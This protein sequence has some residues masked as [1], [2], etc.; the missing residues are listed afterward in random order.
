MTNKAFLDEPVA[1]ILIEGPVHKAMLFFC[2]PDRWPS[3]VV[4]LN[5]VMFA[6]ILGWL[7]FVFSKE[8]LFGIWV[9]L[10][11]I[12]FVGIETAVLINLPKKEISYGSWK[13]QLFVLGAPRWIATLGLSSLSL[14]LDW[15][16]VFGI[17]VVVQLG[18]T[19]AYLWGLLIECHKLELTHLTVKSDKL[20]AGTDPIR[21]LHISDLHV[22]RLTKREAKVLQFVQETKPD[23]IVITG[24]YVNL[25]YNTDPTTHAHVRQLLTQLSAPFGVYATLGSPPVD[26]REEVIP[27]F[28]GLPIHLMRHDW[29]KVDIG[30]G[31]ILTILGMDVT[32]HLPTDRQRLDML[33]N[34]APD[35]AFRLFLYHSPEMM[36]EA[37]QHK[38]DLYLC[39]HTHG[40]QVRLPLIGPILTSSQLGRRYVMGLY[41]E[42]NTRLYN[43]R[44]VGLEGLSAPRVR[45]LAPPEMTLVEISSSL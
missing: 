25:S 13:A 38:L 14:W 4:L 28:D 30:N 44:G 11:G 8:H 9:G 12:L 6:S 41:E 43:S 17:I 27:I 18:A 23:L 7:A 40:G 39:G 35:D 1:D 42:G 10:L 22:E 29:V 15:P 21:V 24:D 16:I 20:P 36:P 5:A 45:F 31:R 34:E 32:H 33:V 3:G 2:I 26:L 19:A 37:V